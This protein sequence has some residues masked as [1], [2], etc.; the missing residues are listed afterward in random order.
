M[1]LGKQRKKKNPSLV[2][3]FRLEAKIQK[4]CQ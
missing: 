3:G 2:R 4:T 1:I